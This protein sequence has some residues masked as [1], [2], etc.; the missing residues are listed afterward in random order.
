M[1]ALL[2]R[3]KMPLL[4]VMGLFYIGAG[5][6]HFVNPE[7]YLRIMPP[8]LPAPLALVYLSGIAEIVVGIGVLIPR[9]RHY[10][11]LATVALLVAIYPANI[12]MAVSGVMGSE[13]VRWGRLPL[14]GVLVLWALWY[15]ESGADEQTAGSAV[16]GRTD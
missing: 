6:L 15:T 1:R 7:F 5:I 3:L 12:Y 2:R 16:Y 9:T 11:A 4:Y 14:Q 13:L 8:M 10:A